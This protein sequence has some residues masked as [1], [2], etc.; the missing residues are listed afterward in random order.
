MN[1]KVIKATVKGQVTLPKFWRDQFS[2]DNF[3]MLVEKEKLVIKPIK[4]ADVDEEILF[5]SERDNK[6]E[7]IP[8]T[9]MIK[10]LKKLKDESN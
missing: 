1:S 10:I 9:A 5:D 7:G 8:V 6:G 3:L 4:I 2:T